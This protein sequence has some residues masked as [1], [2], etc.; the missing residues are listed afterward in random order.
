MLFERF[1]KGV[2]IT[3]QLLVIGHLPLQPDGLGS[4]V[5]PAPE[6]RRL[7][8]THHGTVGLDGDDRALET[9]SRKQSSHS[10]HHC[11]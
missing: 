9:C 6:G 8:D 1:D 2:V 11:P 5:D 4:A 10:E 7:P 3:W